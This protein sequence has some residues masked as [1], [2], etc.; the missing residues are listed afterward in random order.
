M[1]R[2]PGCAL[3]SDASSTSAPVAALYTLLPCSA[4]KSA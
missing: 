1:Q 2:V 4:V 3:H